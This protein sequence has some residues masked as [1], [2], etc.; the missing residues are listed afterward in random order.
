MVTSNLYQILLPCYF[1]FLSKPL[2]YLYSKAIILAGLSMPFFN[3][4]SFFPDRLALGATITI[5]VC[6]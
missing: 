1:S 4:A 2:P 6:L 5:Q 3:D